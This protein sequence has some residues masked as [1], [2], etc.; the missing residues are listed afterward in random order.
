MVMVN[1]S[2]RT[3]LGCP[4][5][6][7]RAMDLNLRLNRTIQ[8]LLVPMFRINLDSMDLSSNLSIKRTTLL[9]ILKLPTSNTTRPLQVLP[10]IIHQVRTSGSS[11]L[12]ILASFE[13]FCKSKMS[14]GSWIIDMLLLKQ[15]QR[16]ES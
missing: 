9:K 8:M 13:K 12:P 4:L 15:S 10:P 2:L 16:S 14:H 7:S 5:N 11:L 1:S 3:D 6:N